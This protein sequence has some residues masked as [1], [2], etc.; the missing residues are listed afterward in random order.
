[1]HTKGNNNSTKF[2][3]S[4]T[5]L[6]IYNGTGTYISEKC[7]NI[8]SLLNVCN[9]I[10]SL[11]PRTCWHEDPVQGSDSESPVNI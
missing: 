10:K 1:M 9:L 2:I 5:V 6:V 3:Q 7:C 8:N 4:K 11:N